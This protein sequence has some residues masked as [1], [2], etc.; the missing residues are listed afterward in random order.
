MGS[1]AAE[2][3][4]LSKKPFRKRKR[5]QERVKDGTQ[6]WGKGGME[7]AQITMRDVKEKGDCTCVCL[8]PAVTSCVCVWVCKRSK[9]TFSSVCTSD[10]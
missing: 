9:N 10:M 7:R 4:S 1:S 3:Y 5:Q 2:H 6:N 8:T